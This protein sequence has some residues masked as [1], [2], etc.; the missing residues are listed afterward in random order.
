MIADGEE[1]SPCLTLNRGVDASNIKI[2][3][4]TDKNPNKPENTCLLEA[5]TEIRQQNYQAE[6]NAIA[7]SFVLTE[8]KY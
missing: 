7:N 5:I 6:C 4:K 2:S 3:I 1:T 8:K